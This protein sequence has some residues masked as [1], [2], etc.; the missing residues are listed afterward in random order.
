M[1]NIKFFRPSTRP[2]TR[3]G[4]W[5][6]AFA[7]LI[8]PVPTFSLAFFPA[9]F[10]ELLIATNQVCCRTPLLQTLATIGLINNN[11]RIQ[12]GLLLLLLLYSKSS[13]FI[14]SFMP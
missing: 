2:F 7:G 14:P 13:I 11:S 6:V 4:D 3:Q 8:M 10:Q 9:L 12:Y 1:I 5:L